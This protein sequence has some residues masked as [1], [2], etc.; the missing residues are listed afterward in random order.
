MTCNRSLPLSSFA[1]SKARPDTIR[2]TSC[3]PCENARGYAAR[4]VDHES[5]LKQLHSKSKSKR[6]G[7]NIEW[8]IDLE[9]LLGLWDKQEGRCALSG[10]VMTHHLDGSGR[11]DMNASLDRVATD[12]GYTPGNVQLVCLRANIM[13]HTLSIDMF[14]WWVRT[15]SEYTCQR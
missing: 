4:S 1:L 15:I 12:G 3:K 5:Y 2:K 7:S 11:K 6:K 9:H 8:T 13:R 14:H 10:V